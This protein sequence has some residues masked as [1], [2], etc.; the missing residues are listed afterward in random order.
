MKENINITKLYRDDYDIISKIFYYLKKVNKKEKI[1]DFYVLY[2]ILEEEKINN[3]NIP[4]QYEEYFC[5][6]ELF[7]KKLEAF[8]KSKNIVTND[9]DLLRIFNPYPINYY[10]LYKSI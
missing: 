8:I 6:I 3:K 2:E 5:F 7:K 1:F 9:L 4:F 10:K